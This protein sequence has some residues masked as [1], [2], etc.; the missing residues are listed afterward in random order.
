MNEI[1]GVLEEEKSFGSIGGD[2]ATIKKQQD[3]FKQFQRRVV[4]AVGKEVEKTNR[5]GQGLIQSAASGVNTSIIEE[6][7]EKMNELW[8]TLKQNIAD[9]EK[10]LAQG[11]LQS[12]KFQEALNDLLSWF[13]SMDDMINNQKPPSSDYK[14]VKAQ[15]QEQKFVQKLLGDRK[16]AV[17]SLIKTGQ[18]IAAA[19]DPSE[20]RRIEGEINGLRDRY[21]NLNHNCA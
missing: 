11:M 20:R 13:D 8:N 7:L 3:D 21:A 6:D 9:R 15:V 18:E 14:V 17:E 2:I 10:R 5:S 12:G 1:Q 19:A 16:G 4:E